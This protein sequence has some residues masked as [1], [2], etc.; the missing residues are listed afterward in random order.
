M[1]LILEFL[2]THS[3]VDK[4]SSECD[5]VPYDFGCPSDT[6]S[7]LQS[8]E[9]VEHLPEKERKLLHLID[10][11]FD[12]DE[13]SN[14]VDASAPH[15]TIEDL[16][17][18]IYVTQTTKSSEVPLQGTQRPVFHNDE[19]VAFKTGRTSDGEER[20]KRKQEFWRSA[21]KASRQKRKMVSVPEA[22]RT[23]QIPKHMVRFGVPNEP[24][25]KCLRN[26]PETAIRRPFFYYE[27]VA[28]TPKGVW[29]TIS[30]FLFDIQPEFVN[31]LHFCAAARKRGY[32]H[33][34]PVKNRFPLKPLLP[35]TIEEALPW[36]KQWWPSWDRR[37][38]L[39]CLITCTAS[40]QLTKRL[41]DALEQWEGAPPLKTQNYVLS[42]CRKWNLVWIGKNKLA[43]LNLDEIEQLLGYPKDHTRGGGIC[44]A[45][46]F[47][48]LGNSFQRVGRRK[49]SVVQR[50]QWQ[51]LLDQHSLD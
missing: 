40:A 47:K 32:V 41:R 36:T 4:T 19:S 18:F 46:R 3:A 43:P 5:N 35:L 8:E 37:T 51:E 11:G 27:N 29:S 23:I 12:V 17:D 9:E 7:W 44:I 24:M 20:W 45:D 21:E 1:D 2:L 14:A 49:T 22:D 16:M 48:S 30:R 42:E 28:Y 6:D 15:T 33:N 26:I 31:S 34:L 25:T 50:D 38:K 39:N 13:A 10:M